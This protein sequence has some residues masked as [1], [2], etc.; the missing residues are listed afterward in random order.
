[1]PAF[2]ISDAA[3]A[4]TGMPLSEYRPLLRLF[5]VVS[6]SVAR[7]A[8]LITLPPSSFSPFP[9]FFPLYIEF[10]G[11]SPY[12]TPTDELTTD[13]RG[14]PNGR[15]T[16]Q[17]RLEPIWLVFIHSCIFCVSRFNNIYKKNEDQD[18]QSLSINNQDIQLL[19]FLIVFHLQAHQLH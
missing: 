9:K 11:W 16:T 2:C 6:V 5:L 1:M 17:P 10:V 15:P 3:I 13:P 18:Q 14:S 7:G 4:V 12:G 19:H 8:S